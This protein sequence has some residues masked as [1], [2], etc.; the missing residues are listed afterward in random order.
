MII[1]CK[2]TAKVT[3]KN[4]SGVY[5]IPPFFP[6]TGIKNDYLRLVLHLRLWEKFAFPADFYYF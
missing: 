1:A 4:K 2:Y 5:N 3:R 6:L